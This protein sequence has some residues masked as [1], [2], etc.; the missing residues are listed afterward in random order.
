M[1]Y[2]WTDPTVAQAVAQLFD[3]LDAAA[4]PLP[5]VSQHFP[6][7]WVAISDGNLAPNATDLCIATVQKALEPYADAC[8]D[9]TTALL[10]Q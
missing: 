10:E 1:R 2:Y 7:H 6:Q 4:L 8:G 9:H 3:F 5:L